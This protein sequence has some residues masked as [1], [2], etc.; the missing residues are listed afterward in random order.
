MS[1]NRKSITHFTLAIDLAG[2]CLSIGVVCLI[3]LLWI[4]PEAQEILRVAEAEGTVPPRTFYIL[5]KDWEQASCVVLTLWCLW[6]WF[7]RYRIFQSDSY[8]L[9]LDI[10]HLD[11]M[12]QIDE[13]NS[14]NTLD[15]VE[16]RVAQL[17]GT[18]TDSQLV[19][20]L[21]LAVRRIRLNRNFQEAND[22]AMEVCDL[23]LE[24]LNSKLAISK[25][26]LW[27]I[28]S[29]G[30]LGTVRGIGVALSLANEALDEGKITGVAASLGVAFNS[31]W[32]ALALSL[33]LMFISNSLHGREERLVAQFKNYVSSTFIPVLSVR[34]NSPEPRE[35][36][37]LEK[38]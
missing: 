17:K 20:A 5:V 8:L 18:L 30:F 36:I 24:L 33:F 7:F 9:D 3:Y 35:Q 38:Q 11:R 29:I 2:L 23:H 28:P 10:L 16:K 14:E 31:T 26:I 34:M 21:D 12:Q 25:Y 22:V 13:E 37:S 6:L 15:F 1:Q 27:A 19:N 4:N 32:V